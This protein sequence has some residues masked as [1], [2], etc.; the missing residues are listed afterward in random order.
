VLYLV[1]FRALHPV[2]GIY[3][4]YFPNT[5]RLLV[6]V[7]VCLNVSVCMCLRERERERERERVFNQEI[8]INIG[9]GF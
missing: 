7:F 6:N 4:H 9:F 2:R 5:R 3:V 1:C 8:Y